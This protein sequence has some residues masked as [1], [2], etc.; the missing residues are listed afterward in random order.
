LGFASLTVSQSGAT[1]TISAVAL[2]S[3]VLLNHTST[4]TAGDFLFV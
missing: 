2:G 4:L 3:L 1:T